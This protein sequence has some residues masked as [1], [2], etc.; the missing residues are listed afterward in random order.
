MVVPIIVSLW[1]TL[2]PRTWYQTSS[3][4]LSGDWPSGILRT[5]LVKDKTSVDLMIC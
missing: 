3:F 1:W 4:A 5:Y 2:S